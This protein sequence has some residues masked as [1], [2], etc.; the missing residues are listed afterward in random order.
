MREQLEALMREAGALILSA[1]DIKNVVSEKEGPAN[2]VTAYDVKVQRMLRSG[3]QAL[4][5]GS[6]FVGEEEDAQ[7]DVHKGEVFIVD[8]IDGTTNFIKGC[9]ASAVSV[10]MLREGQ[11][12]LGAVYD[13]YRDE[14]FFA[15]KGKGAT[16][17]GV[18]LHVADE[19]L[20]QS[21]VCFGTS[22]YNP[23][24]IPPTFALAQRLVQEGLDL[25]RSGSAVIDLCQV[26]RG[27]A[28]LMFEMRL[29]PWDHAAAGFIVTEAGGKISQINGE[30]IVYDRPC[31]TVAGTPGAWED[32]FRLGL[33]KLQ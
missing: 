4:R 26:A 31:T 7:D 19:D 27:A 1:S 25:R 12:V 11:A 16:C 13:P 8:P 28:G 10:A 32:F 2:F 33:D 21:L 6:R 24:L 17:N 29:C 9:N 14:F 3:L 22:P 18:P 20:S 30:P 23:E 5:P 15:E